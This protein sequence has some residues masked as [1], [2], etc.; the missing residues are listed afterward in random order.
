MTKK[1][2]TVQQQVAEFVSRAKCQ[3]NGW[4][5]VIHDTA[6]LQGPQT[7]LYAVD[8]PTGWVWMAT[9]DRAGYSHLSARAATESSRNIDGIRGVCAGLI[10]GAADKKELPS[11][12]GLTWEAQLAAALASYSG[13]TQV[14][15]LADKLKN[16]GHF[17]VINYRKENTQYGKLRPVIVPL[18][19]DCPLRVP[20]LLEIIAQVISMDFV[21]HPDW[22]PE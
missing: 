20:D 17:V 11:V 22:I 2:K 16:G 3:A 14:W 4:N 21:N 7:Y 12:G 18:E 5:P 9:L 1:P 13:T 6:G 10:A 19:Q 15:Q 8:F